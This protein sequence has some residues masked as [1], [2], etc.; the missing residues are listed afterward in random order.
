MSDLGEIPAGGDAGRAESSSAVAD[1][2]EVLPN[3]TRKQP[4]P[5]TPDKPIPGHSSTNWGGGRGSA[6]VE[7]KGKRN[8][9]QQSKKD[10]REIFSGAPLGAAKQTG[11]GPQNTLGAPTG[12]VLSTNTPYAAHQSATGE[13]YLSYNFHFLMSPVYWHQTDTSY[14]FLRSGCG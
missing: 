13:F 5:L 3:F 8:K 10:H 2:D 12:G 4:A 6:P 14:R 7:K 9:K 1:R 11:L